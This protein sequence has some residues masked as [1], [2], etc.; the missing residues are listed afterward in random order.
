MKTCR[1]ASGPARQP[2]EVIAF[3]TT[4]KDPEL[5]AAGADWVLNN[6]SDISVLKKYQD[7]TLGLQST[8]NHVGADALVRPVERS[9]TTFCVRKE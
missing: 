3:R 2:V 6:C 7:L 8:T 4:V 1:L 5:L 9:S